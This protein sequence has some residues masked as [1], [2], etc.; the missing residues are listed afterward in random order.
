MNKFVSETLLPSLFENWNGRDK[1]YP[2]IIVSDRVA[3]I[4]SGVMVQ[5]SVMGRFK[6][7]VTGKECEWNGRHVYLYKS[8]RWYFVSFGQTV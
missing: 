8:G 3:G 7:V 6:S 2:S 1:Q 5:N 4:L